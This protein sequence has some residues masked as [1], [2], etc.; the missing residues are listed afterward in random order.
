M[1]ARQC[2][3]HHRANRGLTIHCNNTVG[4]A[5]DCKNRGLGRHDNGAESI[6]IIHAEICDRERSAGNIGRLQAAAAGS[7]GEFFPL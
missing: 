4:N 3:R 7:L 5:T 2:Q 6:D 1:V